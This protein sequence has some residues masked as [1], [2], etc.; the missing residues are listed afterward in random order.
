MAMEAGGYAEKLGNRYEANWVAYQLLRLLDE[1][2]VSVTVEPLGNDEVGTDVIV[3]NVDT[4]LEHHQCK[5]GAGDAEH[6]SAALLY[7][8]GILKNAFEQVMRGK[9]EFYVISPLP[10]KQ[11]SDLKDS[12]RNSPEDVN[13]YY[14]HQISTSKTRKKDFDYICNKLGLNTNNELHLDSARQ[15]LAKLHI[16]PYIID[17][18]SN[19]QLND[20]ANK[21]FVGNPAKLVSFLKHYAD[22]DDKLRTKI[23]SH[24]LFQDLQKSGFETKVLEAD[25]RITP[26]INNLNTKF[27]QSIS[28][29]LIANTQIHRPELDEL[30][31]ST[32]S[33]AI[34]LLMAEA[35]M[36]KSALLLE[37]KN[38][39]ESQGVVVAPIR[40]D[41]CKVETS[42]DAFGQALGFS[43]TP[44][45]SLA[46]Y[47]ANNK[48]VLVLDQLDAIRWTAAHSDNALHV[49]QEIVRQVLT[50]RS[51]D[52]DISIV[53]AS[54]DFDINED[55]A[56][57]AWLGSINDELN[58][59]K[60][61]SLSDET[62]KELVQPYEKYENLS[63]EQQDTLK[64]PLWLGIY[65]SIALSEDRAPDFTNKLELVK[66]YW[67]NRV[68]E[69]NR[70]TDPNQNLLVINEL[71]HQMI[72]KS[73]F[74]VSEASLHNISLTALS[75]L[76]SV[77]LIT[78]Q[79]KQI[80]FRHQ[81]LFDYQVG[82]RLFSAAQDSFD[83]LLEEIGDFSQ[84][85]LTRREHLKYAMSMLLTES[86]KDFCNTASSLLQSKY[87]RFHLK[88]LLFNSLKEIKSFKAPAKHLVNDIVKSPELLPHLLSSTC[89]SNSELVEYLSENGDLNKWLD[90]P[91]DEDLVWKLLRIL[92]SVADKKPDV[93][94][95]TVVPYIGKSQEWNNR[96]YE[97]LCWDIESDSDDMFEIRKQLL[98]TGV[99]ARFI[100][101]KTLAKKTPIRTL[102]LL[103]MLL[104]H[105]KEILG[106]N[107]YMPR[108][109]VDAISN[110]DTFTESDLEGI[111]KIATKIPFEALSRLLNKV[112]SIVRD[113]DDEQIQEAWLRQD[114]QSNYD[115]VESITHCV[116]SVI[117]RS[118]ES[119]QEQ[120]E[121]LAEAIA[122]HFNST[123]PVLNHLIAKILKYYP[124]SEADTVLSWLLAKPKKRLNC[125]NTYVEPEWVL[126]G[127]LIEKFSPYCSEDL[128]LKL[129]DRIYNY[130]PNR[131]IDDY[132]WRLECSR[133]GIYY[134][135]WGELQYF[136][137]PKLSQSRRTEKTD[138]LIGVLNRK[139]IEYTER[140]F[141]SAF[142]L[143]HSGGM[144]TSP[145]PLGNVL[146]NPTWTKL[147]LTPK[148][149]TNRKT[150]RQAGKKV[151]HESSVEQFA[152]SLETAV[153]N[154]PE[155][156][157]SLVLTLPTNIDSD[158]IEWIYYGLSNT[159][160]NRVSEQY[161]SG[162]QVCPVELIEKVINHFGYEGYEYQIVR[163]FD[164]RIAD[165]GWSND[166]INL[167]VTLS[168]TAKDPEP[169]KLNVTVNNEPN[170]VEEVPVRTIESN[171]I[172]CC[173]GV[174]F[175]A[176]GNLF[177]KSEKL[178]NE[179]TTSLDDA[180]ND[181]HPAV[182][183]SA[184]ELLLPMYN[185]N[186]KL[187]HEKFLALCNKDLRMSCIRGNHYFFNDGFT[188]E[189]SFRQ[190]YLNLT[191]R[192]KCSPFDEVKKEAGRQIAARWF[193]YDLFSE[194][195]P[196]INEWASPLKSGATS[197]VSQFLTESRYN[198]TITKLLPL[199][200][201]LAND[202]DKLILE[203][204]GRSVS[205][206]NYWT[207]TDAESFFSVLTNSKA[208]LYNLWQIFH[209]LDENKVNLVGISNE[210][211]QLVKNIVNSDAVDKNQRA[212]NIRDSDLIKVLQ[213][214]YEEAADDEDDEAINQC[215]DIW[216]HLL[217]AQV[218][219]A[220]DATA[221]IDSG[222][223]N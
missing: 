158:Y 190:Q 218:Y 23:T 205:D 102:D 147:I 219:S 172:N 183:Y 52:V 51:S 203:K 41:R 65:I 60:L 99:N 93:V 166:M 182:N 194:E 187:A 198:A 133:K 16:F 96:V 72:S 138:Q 33:H 211:L 13:Q 34:T 39:L 92:R 49:C 169:E 17:T 126:P 124:T 119:L 180:I 118:A 95:K 179:L 213:R 35:G 110:R 139:F 162:W 189:S 48:I 59:V 128:F 161:R 131:A 46:K 81:A 136:L 184:S 116:F 38:E 130:T 144:V 5:G 20:Y 74:S 107:K 137:L 80:S 15:F 167:L 152:R 12:S 88:Y 91:T 7:E 209:Y 85:T 170:I 156:F 201:V 217:K 6:W 47:A 68:L 45:Y 11:M 145:L 18:H 146:S 50:L 61:S 40:L 26:I 153:I 21:L 56:L 14:E 122:I 160:Q 120:P 174:A 199:Y 73:K 149:R 142:H 150:W 168:K 3:E 76:L 79:S 202:D 115:A 53:F 86:Q 111:E 98:T 191:L 44:T 37:L 212:M 108:D 67:E 210:L 1:K 132:K 164:R 192:M 195:I 101:W 221:K 94:L 105:Y 177:W 97:A 70:I 197:V 135:Y 154:E 84:Q 214:L 100:H 204:I 193:F 181:P 58:S 188:E 112:H 103:E 9:R 77:G 123:S 78:K 208:A 185:Y 173:R 75:A 36:G 30:I 223:L 165:D 10:S 63:A 28:P 114:R 155:R 143:R 4:S 55:V 127:E 42:A 2:I 19:E 196:T 216:D 24:D 57:N 83:K 121:K 43:Y 220:I 140:D 106:S 171:A 22:N 159:D 89:Y 134:S 82:V 125:G 207:R 62:V 175:S 32:Q 29:Y 215:L 8:K 54:R 178:A 141:C 117:E 71:L 109:K 64:I 151:V 69:A 200:E 90:N 104:N 206:K 157:A 25:D 87:I 113:I 66:R 31:Q 222:M 27:E 176:I 129:E 148:E 186:R 163:I